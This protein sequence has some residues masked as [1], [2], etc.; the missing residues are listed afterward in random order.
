MTRARVL[1]ACAAIIAVIFALDVYLYSDSLPGN[2]IT[3]IVIWATEKTPLVP[4]LIG[5]TMGF[6]T[7]HF[8]DTKA[9]GK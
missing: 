2:S 6:L 5:F 3:Q 7:A 1:L 8:F 9:Q 4:W